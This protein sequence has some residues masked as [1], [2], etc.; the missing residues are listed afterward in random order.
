MRNLILPFL[1]ILTLLFSCRSEDYGL[2]EKKVNSYDVYIAGKENNIACYWKNGI[3]TNLV[4][5]NAITPTK[6]IVENNDIFI[7]A[8]SDV[9]PDNFYIWKNNVKIDINQY[10]GININTSNPSEYHHIISDMCIDQG[11]IYLLGVVRSP[12]IQIFPSGS[13]VYTTEL[14]YWKNGIKTSLFVANSPFDQPYITIRNFTVYNGEVYVPVHKILNK[15]IDSPYELGYFKN[16][17][18]HMIASLSE[19]KS[20]RH[21]SKNLNGIYLSIYD[22]IN[23]N[24]YYKNLINNTESY[25]SLSTKSKFHIDGSDIYDFS[26][27]QNY[28]KNDIAISVTYATG[29]NNI[30]D[31]KALDQN[32]YQIRSNLINDKKESY[33]VYINDTEVQHINAIN[34]VFTSIFAVQN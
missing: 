15:F 31:L 29:F 28:F 20:F 18:Y 4:N 3:K 10:I 34:G 26:S 13:N 2:L 12:I 1:L 21:I 17:T 16:N 25:F 27:G 24:T 7:F 30:D 8:V 9:S 14:C 23:N 6:I 5:G 32:V 19:Q 22:N 33:K 11:N